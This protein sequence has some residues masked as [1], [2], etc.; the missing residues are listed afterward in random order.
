MAGELIAF[1]QAGYGVAAFGIGPL[2]DPLGL[3]FASIFAAGSLVALPLALI[4]YLIVR[5][6]A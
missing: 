4:A 3:T 2:H 5:R 6:P 1:Y